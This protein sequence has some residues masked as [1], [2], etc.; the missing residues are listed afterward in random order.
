MVF[1]APDDVLVERLLKRGQTSGRT[2]DNEAS[3]KK[4]LATHH[5]QAEPVIAS[6]EARGL[7]QRISAVKSPDDVFADVEKALSSYKKCQVMYVLGAPLSGKTTLCKS[8][9]RTKEFTHIA[10]SDLLKKQ[11]ALGTQYGQQIAE[12]IKSGKK[13]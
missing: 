6:Y 11:I 1:D 5:S 7:V 13:V 3:I 4:R 8:L 9:A 12:C 10:T 2:D